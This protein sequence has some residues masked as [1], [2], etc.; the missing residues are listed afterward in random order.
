MKTAALGMGLFAA[1]LA[2]ADMTI[3]QSVESS[4]KGSDRVMKTS[5]TMIVKGNRM[6][7]AFGDTMESIVDLSSK[8]A[9][10]VDHAGKQVLE[11]S[12]DDM[13][14]SSM[15]V[16]CKQGEIKTTARPTGKM[17]TIQGFACREYEVTTTGA[18]RMRQINWVSDDVDTKELEPFQSYFKEMD[19]GLFGGSISADLK[20]MLMRSETSYRAGAEERKSRVRVEKISRDPVPDSAFALPKEYKLIKAGAASGPDK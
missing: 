13:K 2:F 5:V 19:Q 10:M 6:K 8:S 15:A 4:G 16:A 11:Q 20:G 12:L 3:V 9:Y 18:A 17:E 14:R 1:A 7:I